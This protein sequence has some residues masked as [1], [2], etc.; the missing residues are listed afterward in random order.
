M[1]G[2][3]TPIAELLPHTGAMVLLDRL[4][5]FDEAGVATELTVRGDGLLFGDAEQVP[6]WA[7]I[8][9][10]AQT[11]GVYAGLKAKQAGE[12]IRLGF[13]LG[14]R[15][16]LGNVDYLPVGAR[17]TVEAAKILQEGQLGVFECR[18]RGDNI[19][20]SAT[21]NVFQPDDLHE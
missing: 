6:A 8:E 7:G 19:D 11:I 14:T 20:I 16:Y 2:F 10:M 1:I 4:L 17:L 12:P 21:L 15:R 18:I 5:H 13:L 3:D 9:Y